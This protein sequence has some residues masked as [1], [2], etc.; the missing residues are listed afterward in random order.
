VEVAVMS[1]RPLLVPL[2]WIV[3]GGPLAWAEDVP[4][5]KVSLSGTAVTRTV[6]DIVVWT[7]STTDLNVQLLEA[8]DSSDAKLKAILALKEPLAVDAK[9][10]QTGYLQIEKVYDRDKYGNRT[11]FRHFQVTRQVTVQ[12]R[13]VKRFDEFLSAFVQ[14]EDVEL[15]FHFDSSRRVEIR[16][17]TRVKALEAARDKAQTMTSVLGSKLGKVLTI[18]EESPSRGFPAYGNN[19]VMDAGGDAAEDFTTGTFAP[20]AIEIRITVQV[21]F[22]IE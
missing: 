4:T 9:D 15:S 5:R 3:L 11:Q 1:T 6:P 18:E 10:L 2:A 20:G 17:E 8:K 13:D 19:I 12:Q 22:E 21:T 7:L 16:N 14:V